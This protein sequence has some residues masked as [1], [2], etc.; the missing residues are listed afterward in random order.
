MLHG[1]VCTEIVWAHRPPRGRVCM[2]ILRAG[3]V[4]QLSQLG[5]WWGT[6]GVMLNIDMGIRQITVNVTTCRLSCH[7]GVLQYD[8]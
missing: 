8:L 4:E 6:G 1:E 2:C 7:L 5:G 3:P